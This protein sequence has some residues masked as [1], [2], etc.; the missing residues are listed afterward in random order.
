MSSF[1]G[2][3]IVT[4]GLVLSLDAANVK[5]YPATGTAWADKSGNNYNGTLINGPTFNSSNGG[6]IV[7]DGSN[8]Y[9]HCGVASA[10]STAGNYTYGGWFKPTNNDSIIYCRGR[11]GSGNGWSMFINYTSNKLRNYVVTTSGG[12]AAY[13]SEGVNYLAPNNWYHAMSV[14]KNGIGGELYINGILESTFST[15]TTTLRTSTEGWVMASVTTAIFYPVSIS[16]FTLYNRALT[17][18]EIL[19]NYTAQKS[20]FGL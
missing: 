9:V 20:R 10:G 4:N 6:N 2:G 1:G 18:Q 19:Q 11:D 12:A 17:A 13:G 7:F 3:K 15:N 16:T 5:S 14:W 8:D